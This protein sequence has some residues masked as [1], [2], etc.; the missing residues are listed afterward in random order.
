VKIKMK[1]ALMATHPH[2][3]PLIFPLRSLGKSS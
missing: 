2:Y 3:P 1:T